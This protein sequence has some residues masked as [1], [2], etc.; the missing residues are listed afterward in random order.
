V[1]G[2][3]HSAIGV[4]NRKRA[5]LRPRVLSITES[6]C[7]VIREQNQLFA[8][9]PLYSNLDWNQSLPEVKRFADQH[10]LRRIALDEWG[11]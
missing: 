10:S 9:G 8:A 6:S 1:P 11:F 5:H 3:A 7:F 2:G 4:A